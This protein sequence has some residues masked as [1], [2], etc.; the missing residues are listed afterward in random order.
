MT[1]AERKRFV[2]TARH[3]HPNSRPPC[4]NLKAPFCFSALVDRARQ[5]LARTIKGEIPIPTPYLKNAWA[6]KDADGSYWLFIQGGDLQAM[7][8]LVPTDEEDSITRR[9]LDAWLAEQDNTNG[10]GKEARG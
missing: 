3:K 5:R 4:R 9:A 10:E 7:F 1:Y 2:R 8:R 6:N